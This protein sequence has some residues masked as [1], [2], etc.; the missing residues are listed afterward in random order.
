MCN[1]KAVCVKFPYLCCGVL[2]DV[3]YVLIFTG[4]LEFYVTSSSF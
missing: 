2:Y 4:S 3:I 1:L